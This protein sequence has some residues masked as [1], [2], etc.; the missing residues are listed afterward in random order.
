MKMKRF[1]GILALI[2][3]V[4][5]TGQKTEAQN[6]KFGHINTDELVKAMP[7]YDS[8]MA[9][10]QRT[11]KELLNQ[12]EIMQ[13]ELANKADA[14]NKVMKTLTDIVRQSKEQELQD[15]QTRIQNFQTQANTTLQ[16]EQTS[17]T[18]PIFNKI[19]KAIKD[20]G[21][22]GGFIYVLDVSPVK[23]QVLYFDETKSINILAQVKSKLGLK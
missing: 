5:L 19:D 12:L 20:V 16:E 2:V 18:T 13:V 1:V 15:I 3:M 9:K 11:Q 4:A 17:L 6:F 8:A 21:K 7:E 23:G 10:L 22:E 14:Y